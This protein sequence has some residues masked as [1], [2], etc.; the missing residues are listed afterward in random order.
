MLINFF[1]HNPYLLVIISYI[2]L[3]NPS[4]FYFFLF[5]KDVFLDLGHV[6][7]HIAFICFIPK[8]WESLKISVCVMSQWSM[9]CDIFAGLLRRIKG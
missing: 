8:R 1:I 2:N 5:L 3:S 9:V 6:G 7:T 4:S